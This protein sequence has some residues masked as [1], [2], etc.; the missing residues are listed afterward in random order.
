[1]DFKEKINRWLKFSR[2]FMSEFMDIIIVWLNVLG[3]ANIFI[4]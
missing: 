1:M 2:F 4:F 3:A